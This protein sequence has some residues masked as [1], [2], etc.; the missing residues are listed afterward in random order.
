MVMVLGLQFFYSFIFCLLMMT[1]TWLLALK[2]RFFSAVDVAWSYGFSFVAIL[3]LFTNAGWG[4]RKLVVASMVC[5]WSIRLG[6]H[7]T[8]RLA[9]H[10]PDEDGRYIQLRKDWAQ[11]LNF[12]FFIFFLAQGISISLLSAPFVF[13]MANQTT[14]FSAFEY[15]GILI[16]VIGWVGES[17]ADAQLKKFKHDPKNKGQVCNVGLWRYSRHPNYFFEWAIWVSYFVFACG[18]DWGWISVYCPLI[19]LTLLFKVTGIPA[20]EVQ[21]LKSRPEAYKR[22]QETTSVFVPWF[23][24]KTP[25]AK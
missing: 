17:T 25:S 6:T 20:T 5:L 16:W 3:Y 7:L 12:K 23:P 2:I 13:S 4:T 11:N 21:A 24:K 15:L 1:G 8:Q 19:M 9:S 18:S 22:Y 10:Y 14:E